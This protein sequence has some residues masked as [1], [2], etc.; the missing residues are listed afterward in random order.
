MRLSGLR[1]FMLVLGCALAAAPAAAQDAPAAAPAGNPDPAAPDNVTLDDLFVAPAPIAAPVKPLRLPQP[2][3]VGFD[4]K[5]GADVAPTP[6]PV[7]QPGAP[8]P[9]TGNADSGAAWAKMGVPNFASVDARIDPGSDR[10]KFGATLQQAL[11]VGG[12]LSVTLQDSFSMTDTPRL[13]AAMP[14]P[15][16][17]A[18]IWDNERQLKFT[19]LPTGTTFSAGRTTSSIDPVSHTS[20]AADQK[21]YGPLHLTTAFNDVGQPTSSKSI[22]ASLTLNW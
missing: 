21:I 1:V 12:S 11:P 5:L 14:P 16:A 19:V 7:Y 17:P 2:L 6:S 4:T 8:L 9:G 10:G 22:K 3:P 13:T 15:A 18:Q 20:F